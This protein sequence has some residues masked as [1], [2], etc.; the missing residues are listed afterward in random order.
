MADHK[1]VVVGHTGT[2]SEHEQWLADLWDTKK[3]AEER[4]KELLKLAR[5]FGYSEGM[6]WSLF[7][8]VIADMKDHSRGDPGI[9]WNYGPPLLDYEVQTVRILKEE[10]PANELPVS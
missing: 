2:Y 5:Y 8:D 7:Y 3:Q 4:C 6:K 9:L 1:Y 10:N